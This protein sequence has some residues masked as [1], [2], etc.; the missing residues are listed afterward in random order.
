MLD[1]DH[2]S[3]DTSAEPDSTRRMLRRSSS[4]RMVV[5]VCGGIAAYFGIDPVLVR[6]AFIILSLA[7]AT[8]LL[9]YVL[10]WAVMPAEGSDRAIGHRIGLSRRR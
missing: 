5:G 3:F 7:G 8:G 9:L 10:L 4:D 1:N 6:A 2:D